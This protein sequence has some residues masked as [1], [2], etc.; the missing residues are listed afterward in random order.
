MISPT[1]TEALVETARQLVNGTDVTDLLARLVRSCATAVGAEAVGLLVRV[2]SGGLELL[3]ST[4]HR[5]SE[6]EIFQAQQDSGPCVDTIATGRPVSVSGAEAMSRRWPVV[7]PSIVAHGYIDVHAF[8]LVWRGRV[9]GGLNI[10][11][12]SDAPWDERSMIA[13]Q[14]FADVATLAV[15]HL[16]ELSEE[17]LDL[18]IHRA[19]EGR[20]VIEQ[21]KGALAHV[22]GVSTEE[23]YAR[24][25]RLAEERGATL[26]AV[27]RDVIRAA[28]RQARDA[29]ASGAD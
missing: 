29:P 8:P 14:T 2:S 21:A 20:V 10:F 12:T 3:A 28:A 25:T 13:G 19:L 1:P 9:L 22:E 26:T 6:L 17:D 16:P 4:S 24:L 5:V 11:A 15:V 7:G 23:A 27:A 18:R